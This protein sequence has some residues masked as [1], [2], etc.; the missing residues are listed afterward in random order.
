MAD[1]ASTTKDGR[2]N[3]KPGGPNKVTAEP[4]DLEGQ[5]AE[6]ALAGLASVAKDEEAPAAARVS[7][8]SA[9]L[10]L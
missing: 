9:I 6:M 10:A 7:A 2:N 1:G 4:R 3:R 5:Y 8:A